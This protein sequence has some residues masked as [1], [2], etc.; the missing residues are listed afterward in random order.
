MLV[1]HTGRLSNRSFRDCH[2]IAISYCILYS[3]GGL[4]ETDRDFLV[5]FVEKR[6][7]VQNTYLY[8]DVALVEKCTKIMGVY[9]LKKYLFIN[10]D[11]DI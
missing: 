10:Q 4:L 8:N 9:H 6:G 1:E 11:Q 7:L 5:F 3:K 2:G